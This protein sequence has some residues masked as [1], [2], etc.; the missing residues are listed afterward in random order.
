[1][2]KLV[3]KA[4]KIGFCPG[5]RKAVEASKRAAGSEHVFTL[6]MLVHNDAVVRELEPLGISAVQKLDEIVDKSGVVAITAHG[7]GPQ[8]YRDIE[9]RKLELLDTTCAIVRRAQQKAAQF[10]DEGYFVVVYGDP[11]HT[12]VK[13]ILGWAGPNSIATVSASQVFGQKLP[14]RL[15]ILAQTTRLPSEFQAFICQLLA[16]LEKLH[17]IKIAV[18]ICPHVVSRAHE[19]LSLAQ[20]TDLMI[21]VG[22]SRSANS[23]RL[24][25][26][27]NQVGRAK[28]VWSAQM[29]DEWQE[30]K[31]A[32]SI[33]VT[34]GTST[35]DW[36]IDEVVDEL[37]RL[38]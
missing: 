4:S 1:M 28:L 12:E 25:E 23:N 29:L 16:P 18:T 32:K 3:N 35:P 30:L 24:V 2:G 5:V 36:L 9:H 19:A 10:G 22:D 8:V 6:G 31:A 13:G 7:A 14:K 17:D 11:E 33:G 15:A 27:C 21:V 20:S 34:S 26:S 38:A 37:S